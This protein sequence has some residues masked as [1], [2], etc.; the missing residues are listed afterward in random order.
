MTVFT[1]FN[2]SVTSHHIWSSVNHRHLHCRGEE[3]TFDFAVRA[4]W[5]FRLSHFY[6][7]DFG[8]LY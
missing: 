7:F 4:A 3:V 2:I 1:Q 6:N 8:K 5:S